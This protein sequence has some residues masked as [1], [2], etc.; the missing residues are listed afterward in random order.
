[1]LT[2][3]ESLALPANSPAADV[4][5]KEIVVDI[6]QSAAPGIFGDAQLTVRIFKSH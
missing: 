2:V 6:D 1:M 4:I 5:L 3:D